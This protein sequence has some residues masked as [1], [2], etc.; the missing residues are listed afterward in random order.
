[1]DSIRFY[2]DDRWNLTLIMNHN[3]WQII[4]QMRLN[5][6]NGSIIRGEWVCSVTMN[7]QW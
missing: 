2:F 3:K 6:A 4:F 5:R 7:G 1:M